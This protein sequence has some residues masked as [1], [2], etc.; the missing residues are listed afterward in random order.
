MPPNAMPWQQQATE[1]G[2]PLDGAWIPGG[3]DGAVPEGMQL[4]RQLEAL[5]LQLY[6]RAKGTLWSRQDVRDAVRYELLHQ[7]LRRVALAEG[8]GQK[9]VSP[10]AAK[11]AVRVAAAF[12]AAAR[13]DR[14]LHTPSD[15]AAVAATQRAA[16]SCMEASLANF[17]AF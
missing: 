17:R 8:L 2:F 4:V 7:E 16:V 12:K 15:A 11:S 14:D 9:V 6:R 10:P 5:L 13:P 1:G 3:P